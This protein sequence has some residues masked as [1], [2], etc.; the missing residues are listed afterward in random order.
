M[1]TC[2]GCAATSD[3]RDIVR[4]VRT[5][6]G[7]VVLDPTG[8]ANGR[9]AYVC[10]RLECFEAAVR[11]RRLDPALRVTLRDDDIDRLRADFEGLLQARGPLD[12]KDGD[13]SA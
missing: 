11:K 6:E 7:D 1:R 5:P 9:G 12:T 3:K 13:A 8:K 4:F 10:A 2:T